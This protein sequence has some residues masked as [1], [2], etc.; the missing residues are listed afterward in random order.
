M[1]TF[2]MHHFS[3][4]FDGL[5]HGMLILAQ[6]KPVDPSK[7]GAMPV[8]SNRFEQVFEGWQNTNEMF[9]VRNLVII[10][11]IFFTIM[12]GLWIRQW[13]KNRPTDPTP[14]HLFRKMARELRLGLLDQW[15]LLRICREQQLPSP[16]TLLL[17]RTTLLHYAR[18][19]SQHL[20]P[21]R[22]PMAMA[23][24]QRIVDMLFGS[25]AQ[26]KNDTLA[27][28]KQA[29]FQVLAVSEAIVYPESDPATVDE[30]SAVSS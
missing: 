28:L 26:A 10:L 16:L 8:E 14:S 12:I 21:L 9:P 1:N 17:S 18:Q 23:R 11:I 13:Y 27:A 2:L 22:A 30:V 3:G 4:L 20:T 24:A 6:S 25:E 29:N 19:Y 5:F 7:A 15:L